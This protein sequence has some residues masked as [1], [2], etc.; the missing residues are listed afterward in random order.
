MRAHPALARAHSAD[1]RRWGRGTGLGAL[2]LVL[3]LVT[4]GP[5]LAPHDPSAIDLANRLLGPT[6]DHPLGTDHMGRCVLS[7]L[8]YGFRVT[9][10]AAFVVVALAA[11]AGTA[12]GLVSGYAGGLP[13]SLIMRV[14]EG[15]FVFPAIAVALV[16]AAVLGL[17]M[18]ATV[19]A[20]AAVH[21][22]EY[23]RVV[24]NLTLAEKAKPYELAARAAGI[25]PLRILFRHLLPGMVHP[26]AVLATFSLSWAILSFSGLSFLG[27]GAEPGT[28]EWGLMIAE[29]R[30]FMRDHPRLILVPGLTIVAIVVLFNVLGDSL[31]DRMQ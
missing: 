24:R 11:I 8:I 25:S 6:L 13:D 31:R 10:L 3:A 21:W 20:L 29:G 16:L 17:G 12:V 30:A 1:A 5:L 2:A 18:G 9:P 19:V 7:R 27:L 28:P 4:V 14:V 22:A 23:A 15:F 26:I